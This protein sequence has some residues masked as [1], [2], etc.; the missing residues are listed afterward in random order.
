MESV[1]KSPTV[2]CNSTQAT[3]ADEA[4]SQPVKPWLSRMA[5]SEMTTFRW[6]LLDD[7]AHYRTEGIEALSVWR[8]KVADFGDERAVELIRDSGV[9]VASLSSAGGFTG[10]GGHSLRSSIDDARE[11]LRLAGDLQAGCLVVVAGSRAGHTQKHV[12]R[13]LRDALVEV[14][15]V[16]A[17]CNVPLALLPMHPSFAKETSFLSSLDETLDV[18][19]DCQ[20]PFVGLAFDLFQLSQTPGLASRVADA[21]PWIKTVQLSDARANPRSNIDRLLPGEGVLPV[22]EIIEQLEAGGYQGH[23]DF[24]IW[25]EELWKQDYVQILQRC[26]D[27]F[28][29][30]APLHGRQPLS[31]GV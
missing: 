16:A 22:R 5:M 19:H 27:S 30:L 4:K 18:L 31:A 7:V 10:H 12:R 1:L 28:Q 21:L 11:A 25:S 13:L 29:R 9:T 15:D 6:S 3:T 2:V 20:H 24:E 8:R 26:R 14:G 23:Y 17:Q